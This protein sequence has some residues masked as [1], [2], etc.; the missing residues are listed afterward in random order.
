MPVTGIQQARRILD[1]C[2]N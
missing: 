2:K 1:L